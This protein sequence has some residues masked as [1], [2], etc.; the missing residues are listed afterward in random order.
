MSKMIDHP[1]QGFFNRL[2]LRSSLEPHELD[3]LRGLPM[4]PK[5]LPVHRDFIRV[6]DETDQSYLVVS[7]VVGRFSQMRDGN[8]QITALHIAGDMADLCSVVFPKTSWA[9]QALAETEVLCIP[10]VALRDAAR[11]HPGIANAFWRDCVVD[12][13]I[14]SEGLLTVGR[15]TAEARVAHLLC[16]MSCRYRQAEMI[17]HDRFDWH[18]RQT[19]VGDVLG[20]TSVHV[21]RM[22]RSLRERGLATVSGTTV[23]IHDFAGLAKIAEFD[24]DYLHLRGRDECST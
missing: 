22:L 20:L 15:R 4:K 11:S 7:G 9:F 16:E 23:T 8:R 5:T 17:D 10:H 14:M 1:L 18:L 21:N 12:M 3:A 2:H 24:P 6:S 19:H 13:A